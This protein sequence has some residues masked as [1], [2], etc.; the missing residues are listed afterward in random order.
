MCFATA[1]GT[2]G[3]CGEPRLAAPWQAG[4]CQWAVICPPSPLRLPLAFYMRRRLWDHVNEIHSARQC[5]SALQVF[6]I[7][8]SPVPPGILQLCGS[9]CV[10]AAVGLLAHF[11]DILQEKADLDMPRS[12]L[13]K[14]YFS[15]KKPCYRESHLESQRGEFGL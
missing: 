15:S 9:K 6:S 12:F 11:F 14:K 5:R 8:P 3:T 2:L 7:L 4:V 13:V 10:Y 1:F